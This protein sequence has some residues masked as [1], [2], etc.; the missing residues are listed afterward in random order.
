M[1]NEE[2]KAARIAEAHR[3]YHSGDQLDG[4]MSILADLYETCWQPPPKVD[5]DTLAAREWLK[6]LWASAEHAY[7]DEGGHD[8][9]LHIVGFRAGLVR[10]RA[11]APNADDV[12]ELVAS[13][14][15]LLEDWGRPPI[16]SL[17]V[18][19]YIDRALDRLRKA[20]AKFEGQ[21]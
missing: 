18:P 9:H 1:T 10:A 11:T 20:L 13:A 5:A 21:P 6:T 15:G 2:L 19:T 8:P 14:R 4:T 7:I 17:M 16:R 12:A 3:R